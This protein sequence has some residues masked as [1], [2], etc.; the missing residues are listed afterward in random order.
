MIAKCEAFM[1]KHIVGLIVITCVGYALF[2]LWNIG[3][4]ARTYASVPVIMLLASSFIKWVLSAIG[5]LAL[6]GFALHMIKDKTSQNRQSK[7]DI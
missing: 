1:V 5:A 7:L 6:G 2:C 4:L 3:M